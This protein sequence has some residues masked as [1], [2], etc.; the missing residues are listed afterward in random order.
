MQF[1]A[2]DKVKRKAEFNDVWWKSKSRSQ[3]LLHDAIFE[4]VKHSSNGGLILKESSVG[5][6]FSAG[7][8]ELVEA[9]EEAKMKEAFALARSLVGKTVTPDNGISK[10]NV[11][12]VIFRQDKT[13]HVG[14]GWSSDI[15]LRENGWVVSIKT[16]G[17]M[18]Y[19]VQRVKELPT[20]IDVKLNGSYTATVSKG[21]VKVGCQTFPIEKIHEIVEAHNK[22]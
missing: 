11:A 9:S 21:S 3:G 10:Y 18:N 22:L 19:P 1:K 20:D 13:D 5:Y 2:G 4:V 7:Y 14:L 15:F 12:G 17:G 16:V 8:F 6:E